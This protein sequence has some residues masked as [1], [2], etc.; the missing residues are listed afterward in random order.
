[1][2][3][4]TVDVKKAIQILRDSGNRIRKSNLRAVARKAAQI[5]RDELRSP[6]GPVPKYMKGKYHTFSRTG[7]KVRIRAGN[8]RKS[9]T[10]MILQKSKLLWAGP[11][12]RKSLNGQTIGETISTSDGFYDRMVIAK[13]GNDFIAATKSKKGAEITAQL[14]KDGEA[15]IKKIADRANATP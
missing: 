2:I 9:M 13:T 3:T 6:S 1:M 7:Y 8:L 12:Y 11:K 4:V 10:I 15:F 5:A 14:Q